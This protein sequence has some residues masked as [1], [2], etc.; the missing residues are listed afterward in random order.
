VSG[1]E[2][3]VAD[4]HVDRRLRISRMVAAQTEYYGVP[5]EAGYMVAAITNT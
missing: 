1:S 5:V 4:P 3:P 2:R